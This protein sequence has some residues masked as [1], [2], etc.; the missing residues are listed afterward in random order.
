MSGATFSSSYAIVAEDS[1]SQSGSS[2]VTFDS[3]SINSV[4]FSIYGSSSNEFGSYYDVIYSDELSSE[5]SSYATLTTPPVIESQLES[6]STSETSFSSGSIVQS[7]AYSS[8]YSVVN[9]S[10]TD[11]VEEEPS[12]PSQVV[13]GGG[14]GTLASG[15]RKKRQRKI[16]EMRVGKWPKEDKE[17]SNVASNKYQKRDEDPFRLIDSEENYNGD[18]DEEALYQILSLVA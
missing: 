14:G 16:H 15:G 17:A 11:D 8:S 5:S 13:S 7:A 18:D 1:L 2:I 12:Q 3:E 9:F 10:I 4:S 6:S